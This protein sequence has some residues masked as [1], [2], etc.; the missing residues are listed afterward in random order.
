VHETLVNDPTSGF[1][2]TILWS[3]DSTFTRLG[4]VGVVFLTTFLTFL[5]FLLQALV[6]FLQALVLL[7]LTLVFLNTLTALDVIDH[8]LDARDDSVKYHLDMLADKELGAEI[9][10]LRGGG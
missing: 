7:F 1:R 4:L 2:L 6:L 10:P 9:K 5:L 3:I 8:A